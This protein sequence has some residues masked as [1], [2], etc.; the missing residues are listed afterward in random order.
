[1]QIH[2]IRY[3]FA[4]NSSSSHSIVL[5]DKDNPPPDN[6]KGCGQDFGWEIFTLTSREEKLKYIGQLVSLAFQGYNNLDEESAALLASDW[7]GIKIDPAGY[8][9]HQSVI[10]LPRN[11]RSSMPSRDFIDNM[12]VAAG[13]NKIA[14]LGGSDNDED[15]PLSKYPEAPG[16]AQL[17]KENGTSLCRYDKVFDYWTLFNTVSGSKIRLTFEDARTIERA[18]VPEL[19][20]L[21]ITNRCSRKC[22][23]CYQGSIPNGRDAD[24]AEISRI[25]RMLGNLNVFEVAIGGGEPTE[26]PDFLN[27]LNSC[28]YNNIIPSFSTR[29]V[30]Y[31]ID[32]Y[33]DLKSLKSLGGIGVSVD[34][35]QEAVDVL[36]R[37]ADIKL[38]IVL[39]HVVGIAPADDLLELIL[40]A[41]KALGARGWGSTPGWS[42]IPL[43][44][45]GYKT[46]GRGANYVPYDIDLMKII[47]NEKI[48]RWFS[49]GLD[50]VLVDQYQSELAKVSD[51]IYWTPGEGNFSFYIDA[52]TSTMSN[53]S[54]DPPGITHKLIIDEDEFTEFFSLTP[55]E[56][57]IKDIVQ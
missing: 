56:R 6:L 49:V 22:K 52:V 48:S 44:L 55:E 43:L 37:L 1:M 13:S 51:P 3:G 34:T 5:I 50:T 42:H 20:D 18:S 16:F 23:F 57:I 12:I 27:I 2:N 47:Q 29:N 21:K 36:T 14:I 15:H 39:H 25:L 40:E 45:L 54:Y 17:L 38:N 32:H 7:V 41:S 8:I 31:L 11:Y 10:V 4:T 19:V 35:A 33:A 26:H 28:I 9:D 53:C 24:T 46:A 30:Q